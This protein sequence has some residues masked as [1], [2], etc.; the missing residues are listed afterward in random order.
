[1]QPMKQLAIALMGPTASGKTDLA[2]ALMRK[3]PVELISV[4]SALVY[5]G[6]DIGTAKPSPEELSQ[7]P[8]AL[9]DI[10]EPDQTY[11]AADF[12][13]DALQEMANITARGNIPL[14]V[15]GTMLYFKA[16][17]EGISELPS[18]DPQLREA[19]EQQAAEQGW[20]VLHDE[21]AGY[22]PVSAMR[23]HPNDP[24]RLMRAVEVYRLTGRTLTELTALKPEPT[25]YDFIQFAIAPLEREVLH[26]RIELR[27]H[28]MLESGFEEEVKSLMARGDLHLGMPSMRCVGY[29]QMWEYLQGDIDYQEMVFRGVVATRQLAKRQMT[30]LKGW[31][32]LQW[33]ESG[34]SNN[35]SSILA[36]VEQF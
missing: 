19:I 36:K 3:L 28:Q 18:A 29:R 21:L 13:R 12:R 20:Q 10:I 16:L 9:I 7:A 27:F 11:S 4:D 30:W 5:R 35:I 31:P 26:E 25:P 32:D 23:I 14:L 22:D 1:M 8:H 15:G 34:A 24:Q 6:M 33:L 17:I 2:I